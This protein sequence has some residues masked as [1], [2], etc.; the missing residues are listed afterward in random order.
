MKKIRNKFLWQII[1][2]Y[3]N[4]SDN[5]LLK[6]Y[7]QLASANIPDKNENGELDFTKYE[8]KKMVIDKCYE[9][10]RFN[11]RLRHLIRE[12]KV[13]C[14]DVY[15]MF[16]EYVLGDN[17]RMY[18]MSELFDRSLIKKS[19][20]DSKQLLIKLMN[21][22]NSKQ[23]LGHTYISDDGKKI[24]I[25][26]VDAL[27]Y[28]NSNGT[29][30]YL[31]KYLINKNEKTGPEEVYTIIDV[32]R[33]DTDD[34]YKRAVLSELLSDRNIQLANAAGYIGIIKP[35]KGDKG[36]ETHVNTLSGLQAYNYQVS[37]N[38]MLEFNA[39][40]L[41]AVVLYENELKKNSEQKSPKKEE[42]VDR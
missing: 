30:K 7:Q 33:M 32:L 34:E 42:G 19:Q 38:Y 40:D 36:A 4:K 21:G 13:N 27:L 18:D 2:Q 28:M 20:K 23:G 25:K 11:N 5:D 31:Y 17:K 37:D 10:F 22:E 41:S 15:V 16:A 1:N 12:G 8:E 29:S 35:E 3:M 24:S 9:I 6:I 14:N 39:E 26:Q